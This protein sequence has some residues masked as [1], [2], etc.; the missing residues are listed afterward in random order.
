MGNSTLLAQR[1]KT[2]YLKWLKLCIINHEVVLI[3]AANISNNQA[4]SG[5]TYAGMAGGLLDKTK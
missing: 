3:L 4:G 1:V 5:I 2:F